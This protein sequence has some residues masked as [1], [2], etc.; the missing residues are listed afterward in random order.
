MI[1][2]V[3]SITTEVI[4]FN[5]S[6]AA[7]PLN[8]IPILDPAPIPEKNAS[9]TLKTSAHGQLITRN[10]SAV[11]TQCV[12]LPVMIEGMIAVANAINTTNG[13]YTREKRVIK[14]SIFGLLA[15]A[16]ST[17]SMI[18]VTIDSSN[19]FSTLIL[20]TPEVFRHPEVTSVPSKPDIGTGSP[21]TGDVSIIVSP[22]VIT[23]SKGIRSPGRTNRISPISASSASIT[24]TSPCSFTRFTT[25][26]RIS[27][28]SMI[29]ERLLSTAFSSNNSPIR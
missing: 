19:T 29:C 11:Y 27:I 18:L 8:K 17:E 4:S 7:P 10:V 21:V 24:E 12:Q 15:A 28:T 23:P 3:L 16:F 14:R 26:G 2:P 5:V 1:V 20:I 22:S 9:G 25:S 13:V 6:K